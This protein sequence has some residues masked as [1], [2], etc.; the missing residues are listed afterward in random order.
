MLLLLYLVFWL[1][2]KDMKELYVWHKQTHWLAYNTEYRKI[3]GDDDDIYNCVVNKDNKLKW[4][5]V[6]YIEK[7]NK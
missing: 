4:K 5:I 3:T 6:F 1:L 2:R 7:K